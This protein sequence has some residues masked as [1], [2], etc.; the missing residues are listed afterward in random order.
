MNTKITEALFW[1]LILLSIFLLLWKIFGNSPTSDMV[2]YPIVIALVVK[3]WT[4]SEDIAT[5]KSK[6][7]NLERQFSALAEDFKEHLKH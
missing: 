7:G 2:I 5:I 1:T 4:T 6:L 3:S